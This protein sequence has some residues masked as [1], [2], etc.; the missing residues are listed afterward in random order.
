MQSVAQAP[1]AMSTHD[2][3]PVT[4]ASVLAA[5]T[6]ANAERARISALAG[7]TIAPHP[8]PAPLQRLDDYRKEE[9]RGVDLVA[10]EITRHLYPGKHYDQLPNAARVRVENAAM[11][12]IRAS[13]LTWNT[14][15]AQR[16]I[17]A[18]DRAM[19]QELGLPFSAQPL[20][21]RKAL[22]I[23]GA[24]VVQNAL[25]GTLSLDHPLEPGQRLTVYEAAEQETSHVMKGGR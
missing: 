25:H 10:I 8:I 13:Q 1:S 17:D 14:V 24:T 4:E 20:E 21:R 7:V 19:C 12:A 23:I 9:K 2:D 18:L 15:A 3:D 11:H 6:D 16:A 5:I 22:A